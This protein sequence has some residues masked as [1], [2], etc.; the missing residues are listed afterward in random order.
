MYKIQNPHSLKGLATSLEMIDFQRDDYGQKLEE[1]FATFIAKCNNGEYGDG[2]RINASLEVRAIEDLTFKRLG[3]KLNIHRLYKTFWERAFPG[4][5][6]KDAAAMPFYVN[7]NH[8]FL[9]LYSSEMLRDVTLTGQA[10]FMK[11]LKDRV[12]SVNERNARVDGFFSEYENDM[13]LDIQALAAVGLSATEITAVFLH[14]LGHIFTTMSH[15]NRLDKTNQILANLAKEEAGGRKMDAN[16]IYRELD[17][18][19]PGVDKQK[20]IAECGEV[21]HIPGAMLFRAVMVK[22]TIQTRESTYSKTSSEQMSDSFASRFG[23]G[24]QIVTSLEKLMRSGLDRGLLTTGTT[25]FVFKNAFEVAS[26]FI[27]P[28]KAGMEAWM[29]GPGKDDQWYSYLPAV[30]LMVAGALSSNVLLGILYLASVAVYFR[31]QGT[32]MQDWTYDDLYNRYK[33]IRNESVT[34]LKQLDLSPAEIHRIVDDVTIID[35]DMKYAIETNK[36]FLNFFANIIF[37]GA[38]RAKVDIDHQRMIE[39]LAANEIF[40]KAAQL[41][42]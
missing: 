16:Y 29:K 37:P 10:N 33:R 42:S 19:S 21:E 35:R 23:Y 1:Q 17:L 8:V 7:V 14:E 2:D 36:T 4:T 27:F 20:F 40:M 13:F 11:K 38:R 39:E 22:A 28:L 31:S 5:T 24:R 30:M 12:G 18:D 34:S 15:A 6:F 41:R 9:D 25:G 32:D 3:I 26:M